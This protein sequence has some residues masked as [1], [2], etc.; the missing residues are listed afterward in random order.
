VGEVRDA[1][2]SGEGGQPAATGQV[3]CGT[4]HASHAYATIDRIRGLC[5]PSQHGAVRQSL[6]F[7]LKAVVAQKLIPSIKPGV[8]RVPT[9]EIMIVNPTIRE[10]ILKSKDE[11]LLDAIRSF[12]NEGMVDF[13]ENLRQLVERGDVD[14]ATALEFS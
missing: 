14:K 8:H 13:N 7:N 11:K 6:V 5:P 1:A 4:L 3:V 10:L 12:F 2:S 9:N